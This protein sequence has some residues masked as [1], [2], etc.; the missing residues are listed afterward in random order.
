MKNSSVVYVK[1]KEKRMT[2]SMLKDFDLE[3]SRKNL[4]AQME[5]VA[6]AQAELKAEAEAQCREPLSEAHEICAKAAEHLGETL[7]ERA[8]L[9]TPGAAA[10]ELLHEFKLIACALWPED[11][12]TQDDLVQEMALAALQV[13]DEHEPGFYCRLGAWR[14]R[15]YLRWWLIPM[16]K[17]KNL[18]VKEIENRIEGNFKRLI[19][20]RDRK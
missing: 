6:R 17:R 15:D 1:G 8:G 20:A 14:A 9:L 5:D 12:S 7:A 4:V 13:S 11:R 19:D 2:T 16:Y 18:D 3:E 10:V